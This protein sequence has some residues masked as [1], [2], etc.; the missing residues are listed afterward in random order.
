MRSPGAAAVS[1]PTSWDD[2]SWTMKSPE[3]ANG[4]S[5][6]FPSVTT[7]PSGAKRVGRVATSCCCNSAGA[8]TATCAGYWREASAP[9]GCCRSAPRLRSRRSR[10]DPA[11]AAPAT[12]DATVS[13]RGSR[14]RPA[15][16]RS[17]SAGLSGKGSFARSRLIRR[18]TALTSPD[19]LFLPALL[20]RLTASFTA[21][22][23]GIRSRCSSWK[24][25][26]RRTSRT[27]GSIFA[28]GRFVNAATSRSNAPCQRKVPVAISPASAR[29]R[30]SSS[31]FRARASAAGRSDRPLFTARNT[32][33][34]GEA[35]RRNHD[36][37]RVFSATLCPLRNSRTR[38]RA[39]PLWLYLQDLEHTVAGRDGKRI[40]FGANDGSGREHRSTGSATAVRWIRN[41]APL[42]VVDASGQGCNPAHEVVDAHGRHRPVDR[43]LG[44]RN[45]R[46]VSRLRMHPAESPPP[47]PRQAARRRRGGVRRRAR[48]G[49]LRFRGWSHR[50][51]PARSTRAS[52]GPASSSGT[53]RMI[54]TPV[55]VSPAITA[56]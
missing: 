23:A 17:G 39:A 2:S 49:W 18:S 56:R 4:V 47:R 32:L 20:T 27:S 28:T 37:R 50:A 25:V 44:L 8:R 34:R 38:H 53:T 48:R 3:S 16:C 52:I 42:T 41:R 13:R 15:R 12:R 7:R 30:S 31:R 22:D 9:P 46:R 40:A 6:G 1:I 10:I 33:V 45:L 26:I 19:A 35:R 29:S 36:G 11:S 43:A 51:R 21:A 54:V 14:A 24:A 5:R 55:T